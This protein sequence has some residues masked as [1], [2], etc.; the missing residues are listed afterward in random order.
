M[1]DSDLFWSTLR[2]LSEC[3]QFCAMCTWCRVRCVRG[4]LVEIKSWVNEHLS[5]V[6][7]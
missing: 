3:R 5:K 4:G 1:S 7:Q 2:E 6:T